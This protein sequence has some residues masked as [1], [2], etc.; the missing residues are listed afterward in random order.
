MYNLLNLWDAAKAMLRGKFI[1]LRSYIRKPGK[2]DKGYH[3]KYTR[4]INNPGKVWRKP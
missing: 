1:T 3:A 4:K 2:S